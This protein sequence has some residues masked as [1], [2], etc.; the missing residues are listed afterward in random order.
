MDTNQKF[1]IILK[2]YSLL[3]NKRNAPD[4]DFDLLTSFKNNPNK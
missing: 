2:N 1:E 3:K 4:S